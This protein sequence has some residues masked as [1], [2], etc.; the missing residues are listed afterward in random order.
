MPVVLPTEQE[1]TASN[2]HATYL[3][4]VQLSAEKVVNLLGDAA[5]NI[6]LSE[7]DMLGF[8]GWDLRRKDRGRSGDRN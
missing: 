2:G 6:G 5:K 1:V 4:M 8:E 7:Y 3:Y